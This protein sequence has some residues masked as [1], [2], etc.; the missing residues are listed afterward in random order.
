MVLRLKMTLA[1]AATAL[2]AVVVSFV[3]VAMVQTTF[4]AAL[5]SMIIAGALGAAVGHVFGGKTAQALADLNGVIL[6]F[7][8][9]DMDGVVPHAARS[10]EVGDI[11]KALKAF[12]SDA[13]RWS[14]SHKSEQDSQV[15]GRLASQQRT[16]ELIHQ[17]RGSIAG[18]LGA[19]GDSA[20]TMDETARALSIVASD[21][22]ERVSVVASAS[23][24]EQKPIG[25][26][27]VAQ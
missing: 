9:W 22:N 12:Q 18:I 7:I 8:K 25:F 19:F 21:T 16:E 24:D 27:H 6:R 20:R 2:M 1:F 11:S 23:D 3:L 14:E 17:F 10:D 13:I 26:P 15:Q 5:L 4:L